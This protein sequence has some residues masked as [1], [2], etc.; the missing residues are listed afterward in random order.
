MLSLLEGYVVVRRADNSKEI[1]KSVNS[2]G[3][4]PFWFRVG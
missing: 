3:S 2:R 1:S 4:G